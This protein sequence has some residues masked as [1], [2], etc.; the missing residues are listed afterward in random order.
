MSSPN[1]YK[2]I[3]SPHPALFLVYIG[4]TFALFSFTAMSA[5]AGTTAVANAVVSVICPFS[6]SL[7]AQSSYIIPG[8]VD[9]SYSIQTLA[10][11]SIPSLPG[12]IGFYNSSGL[13]YSSSLVV[14]NVVQGNTVSDLSFNGNIFAPGSYTASVNFSGFMTHNLSN[15]TILI[16]GP[17]NL[18][19]RGASLA[20]QSVV[21]GSQITASQNVTN[22]GSFLANQIVLHVLVDGPE[23]YNFT[24]GYNVS[25]ISAGGSSFVSL[26]MSPADSL[27]GAYKV[28]EN[29]SYNDVFYSNVISYVSNT[30][31]LNYSVVAN[32]S[33]QNNGASGFFGALGNGQG[34]GI[35]PTVTV[36]TNPIQ[37]S[38]A[39]GLYGVSQLGF[40]N[41]G[42][43]NVHLNITNSGIPG[44]RIGLSSSSL[45]IPPSQQGTLQ[46]SFQANESVTPG[47]YIMPVNVTAS[48]DGI[49]SSETLYLNL[50]VG[51]KTESQPLILSTL[52]LQNSSREAIDQIQL[53]N[54]TNKT[55]YNAT[56]TVDLPSYVASSAGQITLTG[57]PGT[58][59]LINGTYRLTWQ[60]GSIQ[61]SQV[62]TVYYSIENPMNPALLINSP[63][64]FAAP[65][66]A[67]EGNI[68]LFGIDTPPLTLDGGI[69]SL[70][71]TTLYTGTKVVNLTFTLVGQGI[72][73]IGD[74]RLERAVPNSE[75]DVKFSV[76]PP[77]ETGNY[78]LTLYVTGPG[79]NTSYGVTIT[80]G[81]RLSQ[82]PSS[83]QDMLAKDLSG[84]ALAKE[85]ALVYILAAGIV[86]VA[87]GLFVI[88]L[89]RK[90]FNRPSYNIER[91]QRLGELKRQIERDEK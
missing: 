37:V 55:I 23:G 76:T 41:N 28:Y 82:E 86:A 44:V 64:T 85:R 69:G 72:G 2:E 89:R 11:C 51:S 39:Q 6:P 71:F 20:S 91:A 32:P 4:I 35:G 14:S 40:F 54:P 74:T 57:A 12:K 36:T 25:P 10:P 19:I 52:V 16:L 48:S 15:S 62:T 17:A 30:I 3:A 80:V 9:M 53:S 81:A 47:S 18:A 42:T 63:I 87:A 59:L 7:S 77:N 26:T 34:I 88:R 90:I 24:Y 33:Q 50:V 83:I 49:N 75:L 43:S 45:I 60:V 56:L 8:N 1:R 13:V 5:H 70:N 66:P 29:V 38:I 65:T 61:P 78:P 58:V 27:L 84:N 68:R 46:L 79:V 73:I 21:A 22:V 67:P 31:V